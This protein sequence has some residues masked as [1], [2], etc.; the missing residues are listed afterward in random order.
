MSVWNFDEIKAMNPSAARQRRSVVDHVVQAS[1]AS[2][3]LLCDTAARLESSSV[4]SVCIFAQ[5]PY[6]FEISP[7]TVTV[8]ASRKS[9]RVD[10]LVEPLYVQLDDEYRIITKSQDTEDETRIGIATQLRIFIPLW[11]LWIP[12]FENYSDCINEDGIKEKVIISA[13]DNWLRLP[14]GQPRGALRTSAFGN[15][16]IRR[17]SIEASAAIERL[18]AHSALIALQNYPIF[19]PWPSMFAMTVPGHITYCG[20]LHPLA[21]ALLSTNTP[22]PV[23]KIMAR[24]LN[25]LMRYDLAQV[26]HFHQRL[27][28][29]VE[30]ARKGELEL[31]LIGLV[32]AL[33]GYVNDILDNR[34]PHSI[35]LS[36]G[37]KQGVFKSLPE[38]L[39]QRLFEAADIRNELTHGRFRQKPRKPLSTER[40]IKTS[41]QNGITYNYV[42]Q[43]AIDCIEVY[44]KVNN[45]E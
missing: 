35:S 38:G 11:G 1:A 42:R 28:S 27:L 9:L 18:L 17:V 25:D 41:S 40:A 20:R 12:Y 39:R 22:Q 7:S 21:A 5:L 19:K 16:L 26:A 29:L 31:A 32:S 45:S 23:T 24:R 36:S 8:A 13:E 14:A 10:V 4:P 33:E 34:E 2:P 6:Q 3:D 30:V 15:Q 44:K 37:L 43:I